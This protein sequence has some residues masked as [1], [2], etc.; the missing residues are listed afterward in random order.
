MDYIKT[1][2]EA[3][4]ESFSNRRPG[5]GDDNAERLKNE[6]LP[7]LCPD[8]IKVLEK[9]DFRG[10][11]IAQFCCNN[12]RELLSITQLG[13]ARAVGFDIAENI[14]AQ[15]RQTARDAGIDCDFVQGNLLEMDER[16]YNSFDFI[17]FTIGAI[18]WFK[19][20]CELF[21]VVSKCLRPGGTLLIHDSHPVLNMLPFPDEEPFDGEHLNRIAYSYFRKEP[22]IE[23]SGMGYIADSFGSKTFTSF[24]HTMSSLINAIVGNGMNIKSLDEFDYD[25]STCDLYDGKGFPLSYILTAQRA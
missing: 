11:S 14:L 20:P 22:W 1:N 4:E 25:I 9:I 18:T 6:R 21:A 17:F 23:N 19:E 10:K 5:W 24:S 7:F 3:W 2:K 15:A 12:G 16:Y 13:C 8:L